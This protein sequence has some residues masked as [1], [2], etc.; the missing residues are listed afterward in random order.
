MKVQNPD[1]GKKKRNQ[2]YSSAL[3][4]SRIKKIETENRETRQLRRIEE[5][6]RIDHY[7]PFS[8]SFLPCFFF[9]SLLPS[10]CPQVPSHTLG[11]L[12]FPFPPPP[13]RALSFKPSQ[14][15]DT[16][17]PDPLHED[18]MRTLGKPP[19]AH[20]TKWGLSAR[21]EQGNREPISGTSTGRAFRPVGPL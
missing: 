14:A 13:I 9:F 19:P 20:S 3:Q 8:S 10:F 2:K 7:I 1:Q 12:K 21:Q 16:H 18:P 4:F 17:V 11:T 15:V 5:S 6:G